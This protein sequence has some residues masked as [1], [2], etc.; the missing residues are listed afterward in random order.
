M[1]PTLV[2]IWHV[3]FP[4]YKTR[5]VAMSQAVSLS[6]KLADYLTLTPKE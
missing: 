2:Y 1:R 3:S 5:M 4:E 6:M